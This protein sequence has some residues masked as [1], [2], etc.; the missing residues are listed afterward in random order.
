MNLRKK[1]AWIFCANF[2]TF[3]M[4]FMSFDVDGKEPLVFAG[5][6]DY[7]PFEFIKDDQP[8]GIN[9][10]ILR[11]LSKVIHRDIEI[12]LMKWS[13]AQQMLIDDKVDG[14]TEMAYSKSRAESFDFSVQTVLYKFSFFTKKDDEDIH[15]LPDAEEKVIAVTKGGY[16][17]QFLKSNKKIK[18]YVVGNYLDGF[19][20]LLAG[21]VDTVAANYWVGAYTLQE[22]NLTSV[23]KFNTRSFAEKPGF[24][25]V[26]KGNTALLNEINQGIVKLRKEGTIQKIFDRWSGKS[27]V[28][29]TKEKIQK[30]TVIGVLALMFLLIIF[31]VFLIYAL[32]KRLKSKTAELQKAHNNLEAKVQER[33]INL[34]REIA[35]HKKSEEKLT[36]SEEKYRDLIDSSPDLR[37]RTDTEGR[38]I[39]I[40]PSVQKISGY[41]VEELIG[42][43]M[44][45][46]YVNQEERKSFLS[47]LQKNGYATEHEA[48]LKRKD[49]SVWWASTNAHLFKNKDGHILGV[50]GVTRDVT[51]RKQVEEVLWE[52]KERLAKFMDSATDGFILFDSNF[53]HLEMNKAALEITGLTRKDVIGKNLVD[54]MPDIKETPRYDAYKKVMETGVPYQVSDLTHHPLTGDKHIDLKAFKVGEGLGFI[55]TDISERKH[56]EDEKFK[57][58]N[59]LQQAQKMEAIGT[60]AGG[61]AHDFNNI[62]SVIL[63]F[64]EMAKDDCQPGST[65]SKDLDEVL[66]AGNRAKDLVKQILAFSRQDDTERMI[67]QPA[68][69]V[70]ETITM[71]RPSLPTTIEITERILM[72]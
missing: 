4:I 28:F 49:G 23:I 45:E 48:Q 52:T 70:K 25:T 72:P 8:V 13:E 46:L 9:V 51:E 42:M 5:D 62:L 56:A 44:E 14:L 35:D 67:L 63:G 69:I 58:E 71:L 10:D 15:M 24:I 6:K 59:R 26:K 1:S 50:G 36:E 29:I 64:T 66:E 68:S 57:L 17:L 55:F 54:V 39:F 38:I 40:S 37:Y 34:K 32:K 7:P 3:I 61:I 31:T 22:N 19:K 18:L 11:A 21:D 43:K 2:L 20:H 60:L 41:T 53:C 47:L 27:F 30:L 16:P 65:I 12:R 33:T